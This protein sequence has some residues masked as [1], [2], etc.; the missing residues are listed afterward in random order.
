MDDMET[1]DAVE[2][3]HT[4]SPLPEKIVP[5]NAL[6][7]AHRLRSAEREANEYA[8]KFVIARGMKFTEIATQTTLRQFL[9][10]HGDEVQTNDVVRL[11]AGESVAKRDADDQKVVYRLEPLD[12]GYTKFISPQMVPVLRELFRCVSDWE[13]DFSDVCGPDDWPEMHL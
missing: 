9:V 11:L 1:H 2:A 6:I 7:L 3:L 5:K 13:G 12:D 4:G 8:V 10:E